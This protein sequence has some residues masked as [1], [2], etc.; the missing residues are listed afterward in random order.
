MKWRGPKSYDIPTFLDFFIQQSI[1][2][3]CEIY[4]NSLF[5]VIHLV[6]VSYTWISVPV[7]CVLFVFNYSLLL[8]HS[9]SRCTHRVLKYWAYIA[10]FM[11]ICKF[12][13]HFTLIVLMGNFLQ[14]FTDFPIQSKCY[15][16]CFNTVYYILTLTFKFLRHF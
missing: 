4:W 10:N 9:P 11:F 5:N 6:T 3:T 12:L 16:R 14:I 2:I 1:Q 13:N 8:H 7:C 15:H